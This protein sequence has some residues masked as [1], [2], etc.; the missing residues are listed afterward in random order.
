MYRHVF[1]LI[2]SVGF[3]RGTCTFAF[4]FCPSL[5]VPSPFH[6]SVGLGGGQVCY[7]KG[8]WLVGWWTDSPGHLIHKIGPET[9]PTQDRATQALPMKAAPTCVGN[10]AIQ[11]VAARCGT[12][13]KTRWNARWK[14]TS[15]NRCRLA[16]VGRRHGWPG[17]SIRRAQ[18]IQCN[19]D[20][21]RL[22]HRR[23]WH[24]DDLL[25]RIEQ[26]PSNHGRRFVVM[27]W[28]GTRLV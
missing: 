19:C 3:Q 26:D 10:K 7:V 20:M 12:W 8:F 17:R 16:F 9:P 11:G 6:P 27:R 24:S 23:A 21:H 14:E 1:F 2:A 15:G 18:P 5:D 25:E 28:V 4:S 22:R 13:K